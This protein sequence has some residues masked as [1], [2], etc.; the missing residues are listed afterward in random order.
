MP[1]L[2]CFP[3]AGGGT[4]AYR[5]WADVLTSEIDLYAVLPPGR[6]SRFGEPPAAQVTDIV[7]AAAAAI[8]PLLDVP[9][10]LFGHSFGAAI[11]FEV[12]RLLQTRHAAPAALIV[13]GRQAPHLP[14]HR[15]PIAHLPDAAF[16]RE[17]VALGGTP[18]EVAASRE[19]IEL[20]LPMLRSDF[21]LAEGYRMGSGPQLACP[22]LAVAGIDDPCV[23]AAGL[24]AWA[25]ATAGPF[26]S[27]LYSG[28]HF[29]LQDQR[30]RLL[31]QIGRQ[32]TRFSPA[33]FA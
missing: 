16:I 19:L 27:R 21:A 1:R 6:E 24:Q 33:A 5:P 30:T 31:A 13:S 29:Y 23:D 25:E 15:R 18:P 9:C 14:S 11:A 17:V 10:V 8:E 3:H 12:A 32:V 20:L 22:I 28:G 26:E 4:S 7:T 2:I